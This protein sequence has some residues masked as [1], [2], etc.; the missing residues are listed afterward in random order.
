MPKIIEPKPYDERIHESNPF[1]ERYSCKCRKL[2][3]KKNYSRLCD[4]CNTRCV[5]LPQRV[6]N[7]KGWL[8]DQRNKTARP[9]NTREKAF[10]DQIF[11]SINDNHE[12]VRN[13]NASDFFMARLVDIVQSA[14]TNCAY[15]NNR[16]NEPEHHD[17]DI[18]ECFNM[19]YNFMDYQIQ[20]I[21]YSF[22]GEKV[23]DTL[24]KPE[25]EQMVE[26]FT[27]I[28]STELILFVRTQ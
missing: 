8:H 4:F 9:M 16:I 13:I 19:V 18:M 24:Y 21:Y 10:Y 6:R 28:I 11:I 27:N 12:T 14:V 25:I 7:Y 5:L 22:L 26:E 23:R 20:E 15:I 1:R 17:T 2:Q 3:G